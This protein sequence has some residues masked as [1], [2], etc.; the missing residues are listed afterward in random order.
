MRRIT[1]I[2]IFLV[3]L[4]CLNG[5][6]GSIYIQNFDDDFS[7]AYRG[8]GQV[9][10]WSLCCSAALLIVTLCWGRTKLTTKPLRK[11]LGSATK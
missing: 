9:Y 8:R 11:L 4:Y 7:E 1:A 5:Y 10:F 6:L 3:T 2:I